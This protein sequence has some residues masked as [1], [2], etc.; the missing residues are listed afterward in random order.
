MAYIEF[1]GICKSYD[2]VN[3]VLKNID[4]DVEKGEL[5]TLLGPSGCGKSTLLRSL[6]GLEQISSGKIILDGED[7][8]NLPVQ[9]RGIGMVFQQYSLF[10]NMNVEENIAFGLKIAKMD[11]LTISEKVKKAIEMVDLVG[12]EKSYPSQLSGGQQQRVAIARAIV[13]EPKV[14]LLDEPLSAIDAKLRRELQE[15]IKNVQ[16]KLKITTIFVTHDQDEAMIMSD[17]I[18]LMNQGIIEQSGKPVDLYTHP[19]SKFAAEFIG[20]YN[21]LDKSKLNILLPLEKFDDGFYAI[22]PETVQIQGEP[23]MDNGMYTFEAVVE[24]FISR[25]NVLRYTLRCGDVFFT[26]EVL[27]RSFALFEEG[28]KVYVGIEPHNILSIRD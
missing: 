16:K 11:K 21:I 12:K 24:N 25:G 4:L 14:L 20:H 8:T 6:A 10:Q 23:I 26:S 15:K 9:K 2:G 19:V 13:M 17:R 5:V 18:H 22:R 3:Q 28:Q 1:R 7:I 27:F